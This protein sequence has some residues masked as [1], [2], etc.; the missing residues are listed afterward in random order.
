[1]A[2]QFDSRWNLPHCCGA[3]DGKHVNIIPPANSGSYYYNYKQRFSIV[4]MALV[5]ADYKFIFVDIGCNGRVS[6][7]GIFR[8]STLSAALESNALDFPPPEPLP[9]CTLPIPYMVVADAA[10]PLKDYIQKPYSQM[11]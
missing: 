9:G 8:E 10:F 11:D 5:D 6:D 4:L 1:M 2:E 3:L 7:G